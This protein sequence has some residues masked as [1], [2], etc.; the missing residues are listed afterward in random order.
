MAEPAALNPDAVAGVQDEALARLL[1]QRW[2][3]QLAR[4]PTWATRLGDGRYDDR[5]FDPSLEAEAE[6]VVQAQALRRELL[7]LEGLS[8]E[9]ALTRDL[10]VQQLDLDIAEAPC[11]FSTWNLRLY[12]NPVSGF[13]QLPEL[14][15]FEDTEDLERYLARMR[16]A[17]ATWD[18]RSQNLRLGLA[19][20]RVANAET[21]RRMIALLDEL[22]ATPL[23]DAPLRPTAEQLS[24]LPPDAQA[25][26]YAALEPLL[27]EAVL[28]A[29]GRYRDTL[30]EQVLPAA[31]EGRDVGLSGLP[32]GAACYA[33]QIRRYTTL[34]KSAEE[35][36]AIGL[37]ELERI[38][39]EMR[40][41][42]E[43]L[44]GERELA[45]IQE[46]LRGDPALHFETPEE[47]LSVAR[48]S[49]A[50]AQAAM[51][52]VTGR[53]PTTPLVVMP[54]PELTAPYTTVAYYSP[55]G[56]EGESG[57]YRVN[58]WAPDTRTRYEA[59]A[60]AFHE[61]VPGHH[62]QIALARERPEA[63]A[64]RRHLSLNAY[65]EG[66][67]LYG[68]R[69]ADE[70]GLYSGPLDRMGMLSFDAWRA[71]RL[72]VDTGIH[73]LGWSREEAV[74]FMLDATLLAPNNV[75]NEVDRYIS[76]PGQALGYKLGQLEI[77]A[78]REQ[79]EAALGERFSLAEFH[80]LIL[81]GGP[82]PLD[83]LRARVEA[84]ISSY[85]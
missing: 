37:A 11:A 85:P 35:I 8:G 15:P 19:V 69:L 40:D 58:T 64:F 26:F 4:Y 77:L 31:R 51:P 17:P 41:L 66:W 34:E 13:A 27:T 16:A 73:H 2:E 78:L 36:H 59:E 6:D 53:Q 7:A 10:L 45:A 46:R 76:W 49:V 1:D 3:A 50:R 43:Q 38:H 39:G 21:T 82:L 71:A 80:D 70:L 68:E 63:P 79:A 52:G 84:W 60:L 29:L 20:G 44:W 28:P 75:D 32:E 54:I 9:D 56:A 65:V 33:T 83:L 18:A 42:G 23:Q 25:A 30:A 81:E 61:A 57:E 24:A 5:L 72:V 12:D 74:A 48:A 14:H 55:P 47:I 67:A 62:F 22:L